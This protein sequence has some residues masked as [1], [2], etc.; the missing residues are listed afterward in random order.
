MYSYL[1]GSTS[2]EDEYQL[3]TR[4]GVCYTIRV[5]TAIEIAI[6]HNMLETPKL[7]TSL[8]NLPD[9]VFK[10]EDRVFIHVDDAV[11]LILLISFEAEAILVHKVI[12]NRPRPKLARKCVILRLEDEVKKIACREQ[13]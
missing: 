1:G 4:G 10:H 5:S 9:E 13:A 12:K 11:D 3:I 7:L 8:L 6:K 2:P